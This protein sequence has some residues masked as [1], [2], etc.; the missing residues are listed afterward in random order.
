MKTH[1]VIKIIKIY[2]RLLKS[3]KISFVGAAYTRMQKLKIR[4]LLRRKDN[5]DNNS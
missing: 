3:G 5:G 2:E 1:K 4:R